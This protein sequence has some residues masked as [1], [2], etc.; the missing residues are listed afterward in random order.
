MSKYR[1]K[2]KKIANQNYW[3]PGYYCRPDESQTI[4]G[5]VNTDQY[6]KT[7]GG[8]NLFPKTK[9]EADSIAYKVLVETMGIDPREIE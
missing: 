5:I 8:N 4:H 3:T 9:E 1:I 2:S 6:E 7:I